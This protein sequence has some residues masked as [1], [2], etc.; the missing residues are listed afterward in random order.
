MVQTSIDIDQDASIEMVNSL[1]LVVAIAFVP[2]LII[3]FLLSLIIT[4]Q[5]LKPVEEITKA[6][7]GISSTNLETLLPVSK[8]NDEL[9]DLAKTFNKL[10]ENLKKDFQREINFTSDVSHELKTPVAGILG[11]ANLLKRWGKDDPKQL[12]ES[13]DFIINEAN[14]MESIINNLLQVSKLEND[15]LKPV[16]SNINMWGMFSRLKNEFSIISPST[17][18]TFNENIDLEITSDMELLHQVLTAIISNSI[19]YGGTNVTLSTDNIP[20]TKEIQIKVTDNGPGFTDEILPHIFERFFRGDKSH[21]RA[22]GGAGLGLSISST[23]IK[24]LGGSIAAENCK[25]HTGAVIIIRLS[26]LMLIE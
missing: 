3:S 18:I 15:I 13:L 5:T 24:A 17:N 8:N 14:S 25:E 11:Q 26:S 19:K 10:F 2:I 12:E 7:M 1:P 6:A 16:I 21:N 4:K 23:I 9:D 20:E 22:A